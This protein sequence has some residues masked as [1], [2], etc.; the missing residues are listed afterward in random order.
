MYLRLLLIRLL[1]V[2]VLDHLDDLIEQ[3]GDKDNGTHKAKYEDSET[4]KA[5]DEDKETQQ[6]KHEANNINPL[7]AFPS[8]VS[9]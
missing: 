4:H 9:K 2:V 3:D 7:S 1:F 5:K 6:E 8:H